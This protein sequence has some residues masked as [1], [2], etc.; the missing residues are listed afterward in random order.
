MKHIRF[1]I[2]GGE[3]YDFSGTG[4]IQETSP[5]EILWTPG[6]PYARLDY[7]VP[8]RHRKAPGKGYD[9]YTT[10]D[11]ALI[12]AKL[13]FPSTRVTINRKVERTPIPD[14]RVRFLLPKGWKAWST[15]QPAGRNAFR[16]IR[17]GR[18]LDRPTGWLALGKM[19][20]RSRRIAGSRIEIVRSPNSKLPSTKILDLYAKT[21][22]LLRRIYDR[23]PERLL[24]VSAPDPMWRGG[25]SGKNSLYIHADRPLR[26]PDRTSP[27]LH[28]IFHVLAPFR[29]GPDGRWITEGLAE[30]YSLALQ[31]R[32]GVL[33]DRSFK[34]ALELF[35]RYGEWNVDLTTTHTLAATNNSAPLVMYSL[36]AEIRKV[37]DGASSLD[38]V[39]RELVARRDRATT[40]GFLGAVHSVTKGRNFS[41]FF[42]RH[43]FSGRPPPP[44]RHATF[45]RHPQRLSRKLQTTGGELCAASQKGF[46]IV[47][48]IS[49]IDSRRRLYSLKP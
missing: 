41:A 13:L 44:P 1:G 22:P 4:I 48:W 40:A 31:H 43:V 47:K 3:F 6:S 33:R 34:R 14:C 39:V 5:K 8:L 15:M 10:D 23:L 38:D 36:D 49:P 42:Q 46:P 21:L 27:P 9:S 2:G 30:Y 11:W 24:I 12:R 35:L 37:T 32:A 45:A 18:F 7:S 29:P 20:A 25:I 19:K 17:A 28:E 26:T 16:P